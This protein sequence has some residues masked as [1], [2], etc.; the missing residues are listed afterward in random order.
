[1]IFHVVG[2]EVVPGQCFQVDVGSGETFL[3]PSGWIHAVYTPEDALVFGGNF[4]TTAS[5]GLQ[6]QVF[7]IEDRTRLAEEREQA[8]RR[9]TTHVRRRDGG[10]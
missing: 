1:M 2:L 10:G 9:E 8:V 4:L 5:I 6:L 7:E 3:F